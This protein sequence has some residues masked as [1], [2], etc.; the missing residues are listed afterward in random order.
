MI[1]HKIINTPRPIPIKNN[2]LKETVVLF[3]EILS[4]L[5]LT[6]KIAIINAISVAIDPKISTKN[7][8]NDSLFSI[9]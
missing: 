7:L 2:F 8:S 3:L 6:I 5:F 9:K 4:V 1:F